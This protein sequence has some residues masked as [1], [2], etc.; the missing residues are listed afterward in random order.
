MNVN[1]TMRALTV[2]M[3]FH[4]LQCQHFCTLSKY[5]GLNSPER[6]VSTKNDLAAQSLKSD[7]EELAS[8][9][10]FSLIPSFYP[11]LQRLAL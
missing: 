7:C 10:N 1:N 9:Y 6:F 5:V 8:W 3:T 2:N 4:Y 11:R